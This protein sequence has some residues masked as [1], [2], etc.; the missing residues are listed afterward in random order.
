MAKADENNQEKVVENFD[1]PK[2]G[3]SDD[4]MNFMKKYNRNEIKLAGTITLLEVSTPA[5]KLDKKTNQPALDD[6]GN[7]TYWDPFFTASISFEGGMTRVNLSQKLFEI[8]QQGERY[9]FVGNM[10]NAFGKVQPVF[11]DVQSIA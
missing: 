10:G 6:N 1:T 11:Y 8:L 7:P 3:S 2:V 5:Q 4:M 9:L